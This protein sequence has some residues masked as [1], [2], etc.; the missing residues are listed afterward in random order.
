VDGGSP[1]FV[2][3]TF[4]GNSGGTSSDIYQDIF[5]TPAVTYSCLQVARAGTGN[6]VLSGS[7]FGTDFRLAPGS[8][9]ADA[10]S[11][12][13]LPADAWDLDADGDVAEPLPLDLAGLPRVADD[14][15][16]PGGTLPDMGAYETP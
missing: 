8:V 3:S 7:P 11:A 4:W 14:A 10:G 13:A 9:C 5:S 16:A 6:V 2:N 15:A 1:V 12:A